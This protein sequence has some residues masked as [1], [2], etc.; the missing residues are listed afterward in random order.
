MSPA[1]ELLRDPANSFEKQPLSA[2]MGVQVSG[3]SLGTDS[4]LTLGRGGSS[5]GLG[6]SSERTYMTLQEIIDALD[7]SIPMI[8]RHLDARLEYVQ[9]AVGRSARAF[10]ALQLAIDD[11]SDPDSRDKLRFEMQHLEEMIEQLTLEAKSL[12]SRDAMDP[13][14]ALSVDLKLAVRGPAGAVQ[15]HLPI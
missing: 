1:Q 10:D 12:T 11:V 4:Y 5:A 14:R 13:V 15:R 9:N 6:A 2:P 3:E 8:E 7:Q